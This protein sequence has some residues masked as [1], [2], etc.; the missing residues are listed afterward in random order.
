MAIADIATGGQIARASSRWKAV[1]AVSRVA[2]GI[3]VIFCLTSKLSGAPQQC[4]WQLIDGASAQTH[5]RPNRQKDHNIP[6]WSRQR[7]GRSF[8]GRCMTIGHLAGNSRLPTFVDLP[9]L[10]LEAPWSHICAAPKDDYSYWP[11]MRSALDL[12]T[13]AVCNAWPPS[14]LTHHSS[15]PSP[16]PDSHPRTHPEWRKWPPGLASLQPFRAPR[17]LSRDRATYPQF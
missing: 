3:G 9:A 14:E 15:L 7:L 13:Q 17:L 12:G 1:K 2:L 5:V 16:R 4:Y 8:G 11:S 6:P 10:S